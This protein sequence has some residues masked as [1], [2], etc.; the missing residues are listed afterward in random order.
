MTPIQDVD[1]RFQQLCRAD[2]REL[3]RL[4]TKYS[5][6]APMPRWVLE[7]G[8]IHHIL[9]AEFGTAAVQQHTLWQTMVLR[10]SAE[11]FAECQ[12]ALEGPPPP[13][14]DILERAEARELKII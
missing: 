4:L 6:G 14:D 9:V 12:L 11:R 5:D 1:H 13:D 3:N 10:Q 8:A 2:A 7:G